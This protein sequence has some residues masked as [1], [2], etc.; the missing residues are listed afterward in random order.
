MTTNTIKKPLLIVFMLLVSCIS[1]SQ[2]GCWKHVCGTV[3]HT[4]AIKNDGILWAWGLN[5]SGQL[6]DGTLIDRNAPIQIGLDN[7]WKEISAGSFYSIALKK[8]GTMWIW[9]SNE[10]GQL[11]IG[12]QIDKLIPTQIG[13]GAF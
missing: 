8:D 13:V 1:F 12:D 7:N 6:G 4:L 11:G 2:T 10:A 3:N 5:D 9:G